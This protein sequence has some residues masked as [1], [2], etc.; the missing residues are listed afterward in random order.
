MKTRNR[1]P[2][3]AKARRDD[4]DTRR[5]VIARRIKNMQSDIVVLHTFYNEADIEEFF[6]YCPSCGQGHMSALLINYCCR[7]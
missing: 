3:E 7:R 2:S 1:T 4:I 6:D 5:D